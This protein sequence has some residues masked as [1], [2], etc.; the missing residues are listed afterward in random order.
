MYAEYFFEPF[1]RKLEICPFTPKYF[2]VCF[3]RI[4]I[5]S[6]NHGTVIRIRWLTSVPQCLIHNTCSDF[7]SCQN[8]VGSVCLHGP[9]SSPAPCMVLSCRVSFFNSEQ[10]ISFCSWSWHFWR[11]Q[12]VILWR[13]PQS[14]CALCC[15]VTTRRLAVPALTPFQCVSP[16]GTCCTFV[17]TSVTWTLG[18]RL[19][20]CSPGFFP[21]NLLFFSLVIYK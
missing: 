11:V 6:C 5:F 14:G 20:W 13:V 16:G 15:A 12:A 7:V 21:V 1:E 19:K 10:L 8:N 4:R 18:T 9:G 2:N 3:L 17:L